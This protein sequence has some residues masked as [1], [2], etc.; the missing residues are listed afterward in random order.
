MQ[1]CS[2]RLS[3]SLQGQADKPALV[4]LHGLLGDHRDWQPVIEELSKEY[5]CLA[6]DLPGHGGSQHFEAVGFE[7]TCNKVIATISETLSSPFWLVG[8]SLGARIAMYL[9][10]HCSCS[11]GVTSVPFAGL[12]IE[13]GHPG[14][15][16]PERVA[17]REH[18]EKWAVRFENEPIVDVLEDWYQQPVFS[19]LNHAQRQS[20]IVKRSDNLG[21][22]VASMLR[23]TSLS[24]QDFLGDLLRTLPAKV[25]YLCGEKDNRFLALAMHSGLSYSIVPDAGHNIHAEQPLLYCQ[26]IKRLI[27]PH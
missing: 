4:F 14:L 5:L 20:L 2:E 21:T 18:D 6:I 27:E 8:Y 15:P 17:R 1:N 12:I 19:S 26:S 9:A 11:R 22:K 13:N 7:D 16:E 23:A 10:T 25:H 24:Q 3:Y